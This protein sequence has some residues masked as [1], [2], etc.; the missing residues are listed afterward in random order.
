V[1]PLDDTEKSIYETILARR[2]VRSYQPQIV[3]DVTLC[4]L[5]E[6]AVRAP[7]AMHREPWAFV[8]IQDK[9]LLLTISN[10]AKALYFAEEHQKEHHNNLTH[11]SQMFNSPD[12][13]IFYDASTLILIC[14][15]KSAPFAEAD[16]WLAAEN[17]ML[18]ACAM[19]LGTCVI[20]YALPAFNDADIRN[21]LSITDDYQVVAP[22]I[23]GYQRGKTTPSPRKAPVILFKNTVIN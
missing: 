17:M 3:D 20:G 7:T 13:N 5:L 21:R 1:L 23:V 9:S 22:I 19:D 2:S 18:V 6:A 15:K 4:V 8:I 14:G 10:R 11:F 16:C 12:F